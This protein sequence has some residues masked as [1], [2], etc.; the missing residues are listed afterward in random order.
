MI[1]SVRRAV[2]LLRC[3]TADEPELSVTA[4]S[5]KLRVHK[6]T[7]SRILSTLRDDGLVDRNPETGEYRLGLGLLELAG[8]VVL[9]ADM[10]QVARPFLRQLSEATMETVN[11]AVLD[12]CES[13]NIEQAVS[14]H[15]RVTGFGWVGRKTPLHA[16][17]TGKVLLAFLPV[18]LQGFEFAPLTQNT[19]T[20]AEILHKELEEIRARGYA[21]GLEELEVGLNAVAAPVRDHTGVVVAAISVTGPSPRLSEQRIHQD[22]AQQ[23]I[24]C[25]EQISKALGYHIPPAVTVED[26]LNGPKG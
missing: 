8:L 3:F 1:G 13:L 26:S 23:V 5:H 12:G 2:A 16:S 22:V 6:S 11:L 21:T 10:R 20:N 19:I 18:P 24:A 4:L 15:R 17:S 14:H 9:H 7:V 25:A